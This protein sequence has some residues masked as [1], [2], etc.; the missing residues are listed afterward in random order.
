MN[1]VFRVHGLNFAAPFTL[2]AT[3]IESE[4]VDWTIIEGLPLS[5]RAAG[6]NPRG[7][8]VASAGDDPIIYSLTRQSASS[9]VF[10]FTE[11]ADIHISVAARRI[12]WHLHPGAAPQYIPL[13]VGGNVIA[14]VCLVQGLLAL[15]ASAVEVD[16]TGIAFIGN[17]GAGKSTLAAIACLGGARL[18]TDDILRIDV[19]TG[20][21][22]SCYRGTSTVRLREESRPLV[23]DAT[24]TLRAS[25]TG[26]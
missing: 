15:H 18:I 22:S 9:Y 21:P 3:T 26:S 2:N 20:A 10:R 23:P 8:V 16:A 11:Y 14:A 25:T 12:S 4:T 7:S 19:T 17:T 6:T 24:A 13:L 5:A 1:E